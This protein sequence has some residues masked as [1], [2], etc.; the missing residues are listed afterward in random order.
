M[1]NWTDFL[2]EIE[3]LNVTS[4]KTGTQLE[5]ID[6]FMLS[7]FSALLRLELEDAEKEK[8]LRYFFHVRWHVIA[9][10]GLD[11]TFNPQLPTNQFYVKV[12]QE[13]LK[14]NEAVCQILMPSIKKIIGSSYP[15]ENLIECCKDEVTGEFYVS[16]F[17]THQDDDALISLTTLLNLAAANT[18]RL[19]SGD[20]DAFFF[21]LT[22]ADRERVRG[23][24]GQTS[25]S[26]FSALEKIHRIR[27]NRKPSV[28]NA[29]RELKNALLKSSKA[30]SG[31][32][33]VANSAECNEAIIKFHTVWM[34]L[35]ATHKDKVTGCIAKGSSHTLNS[36]LLC[37]FINTKIDVTAEEFALWESDKIFP[38]T[39]QIGHQLDTLLNDNLELNNIPLPG[40]ENQ[41]DTETFPD[42]KIMCELAENFECAVKTRSAINGIDDT[43]VTACFPMVEVLARNGFSNTPSKKVILD[44]SFLIHDVHDL[45]LALLF[46]PK[47]DWHFLFSCIEE[48]LKI[49]FS[50]KYAIQTSYAYLLSRLPIDDWELFFHALPPVGLRVPAQSETLFGYE[51]ALLLNEIAESKWRSLREAMHDRLF[52]VFSTGQDLSHFFNNISIDKHHQVYGLFAKHIE[53]LVHDDKVFTEIFRHAHRD[54]WTSLMSLFNYIIR[55]KMKHHNFLGTD[56]QVFTRSEKIDFID[57]LSPYL[58]QE[59]ITPQ[60]I[61]VVFRLFSP[62]EWDSEGFRLLGHDRIIKFLW[63]SEKIAALLNEFN[64]SEWENVYATFESHIRDVVINPV[65]LIEIYTRTPTERWDSLSSLFKLRFVD[66]LSRF[67]GSIMVLINPSQRFLFLRSI[68]PYVIRVP[69]KQATIFE[70]LKILPYDSWSDAR[71]LLTPEI[72]FTIKNGAHISELFN[73]FLPVDWNRLYALLEKKINCIIRDEISFVVMINDIPPVNLPIMFSLFQRTIEDF[74]QN[75]NFW[76]GVLRS[77]KPEKFLFI[78]PELLKLCKKQIPFEAISDFVHK[79]DGS[80]RN[81]VMCVF[82]KKR[83][84]DCVISELSI[85]AP[86]DVDHIETWNN[87]AIIHAASIHSFLRNRLAFAFLFYTTSHTIWPH[88]CHLFEVKLQTQL[89]NRNFLRDTLLLFSDEQRVMMMTCVTPYLDELINADAHPVILANLF[90]ALPVTAWSNV[91]FDY[92]GEQKIARFFNDAKTIALFINQFDVSRWEL[93]FTLFNDVF[94][95]F[96][97]EPRSI[98]DLFFTTPSKNWFAL[99]IT[100]ESVLEKYFQSN[101]FFRDL[102]SLF[103]AEQKIA[104]LEAVA[105]YFDYLGLDKLNVI[106]CLKEC[107]IES[108]PRLF[109]IIGEKRLDNLFTNEKDIGM[110]LLELH[111]HPL[112]QS[113][114]IV[115]LHHYLPNFK[116]QSRDL[117]WLLTDFSHCDGLTTL[118]LEKIPG[119]FMRFI[120]SFQMNDEYRYTI[121]AEEKLVFEKLAEKLLL[122]L[123]SIEF[124]NKVIANFHAMSE[125]NA[126]KFLQVFHCDF[127]LLETQC[128]SRRLSPQQ[129]CF[130]KLKMLNVLVEQAKLIKSKKSPASIDFSVVM[131]AN[132]VEAFFGVDFFVNMLRYCQWVSPVLLSVSAGIFHVAQP[133]QPP[134]GLNDSGVS[135]CV[136]HSSPAIGK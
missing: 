73:A 121:P 42:Q 68:F 93:L 13:I 21:K 25:Q 70:T 103:G 16:S 123:L 112:Q 124:F 127:K 99:A 105:V 19:F 54:G 69:Y 85:P 88:L 4:F 100:L 81:Q 106:D 8:R 58:S 23:I 90:N 92:F 79:V 44:L 104:F 96:L 71:E 63:N 75:P 78:L 120:H 76:F 20:N 3:A 109:E 108:Y 80:M 27:Y 34:A 94:F 86:I 45:V 135:L 36:Y 56:F 30:N 134:H 47:A 46:L 77:P 119:V 51:F 2:K 83:I 115:A 132:Q 60:L 66:D 59:N 39:H 107:P 43:R 84:V 116:P 128:A 9:R 111:D 52:S 72:E 50:K 17:L 102:F 89:R 64:T 65:S 14:K 31:S 125:Q 22:D 62:R 61:A 67:S 122:P 110:V 18:D 113:A 131:L 49:I 98:A 41:F 101:S 26:Y 12:A 6:Q 133:A 24:T 48:Q 11:Y 15:P 87:V 130:G 29:L 38:C 82:D 74:S 126:D 55:M 37:L 118:F 91:Y 97:N 5:N 114:F 95:P 117:H 33:L 1:R 53:G 136:D 129:M 35:S 28:G 7:Q 10:S 40:M 57:A 32:E